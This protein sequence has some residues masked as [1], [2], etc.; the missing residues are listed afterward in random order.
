VSISRTAVNASRIQAICLSTLRHPI[1]LLAA[2]AIMLF[3]LLFF[4]SSPAYSGQVTLA[5][6]PSSAGDLAGYRVYSGT[7]SRSYSMKLDVGNATSC[8]IKGLV[9]G[10]TYYFAV[11]AVDTSGLESSYSN[12]ATMTLA[13]TGTPA[14]PTE[15]PTTPTNSNTS[16]AT[17]GG[18]GG[19][20]G[21]C[22]I[23]TAV[24]GS[25]LDPH[26]MVLRSFRDNIL[27]TNRFGAA[28]VR[29]Y[30][31]TSPAVAAVIA[32]SS[33][34]RAIV[35][36]LLLPLIGFG[37]VCLSIGLFPALLMTALAIYLVVLGVRSR[38]LLF[39][40]FPFRPEGS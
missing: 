17:D 36:V 29:F 31:A 38:K 30:Y 3:S 11:T 9:D 7:T 32:D 34:L 15:D 21:G 16:A 6:D 26:V 14:A 4:V 8:V 33:L 23:A 5:W 37:Y 24:Y 28:F 39:A 12:E 35:R 2:C 27:L 1:L 40:S 25:Y 22:F 13:S 10:A 20:G 18:G 19:G